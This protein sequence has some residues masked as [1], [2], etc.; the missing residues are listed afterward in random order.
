MSPTCPSSVSS[1][2]AD[3]RWITG[4]TLSGYA[5]RMA[6]PVNLMR[7]PYTELNSHNAG[8]IMQLVPEATEDWD[9]EERRALTFVIF[10]FDAYMSS[11]SGWPTGIMLDE[12]VSCCLLPRLLC[13]S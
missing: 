6:M 11:S 9:R 1:C 5:L 2:F 4:Y 3:I 10:L 13:T 12:L 8:Q 7:D